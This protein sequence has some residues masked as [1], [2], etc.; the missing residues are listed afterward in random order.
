VGFMVLFTLLLFFCVVLHE[1]GHSLVAQAFGVKVHDITLWPIGGVARLSNMPRRPAHEFLI[2]AA[3]PAVNILL[4]VM[5][6]VL[7]FGLIGPAQLLRTFTTGRG[8]ARLLGGQTAESLVLLLALQNVLLALFNLVPAFPLDGGRLLRS[9]LAGFLPFRTATRTASYIGQGVA[10]VL[11]GASFIPPGNFFLTLVAAFVFLGAW[12]ERSQVIA[13][14]SLAGLIV[15]DAMQPLGTRLSCNDPVLDTVRRIAAIPQSAF[16]VVE[17]NR[18]AGIMTRGGLLAVAKKAKATETVGQHL[19]RGIAQ[20]P[21]D[22]S[23]VSAQ[24]RLQTEHAAVVVENGVILGL[25]TRSDIARLTE[26]LEVIQ[27]AR[28][29]ATRQ[30]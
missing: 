25:I 16:A 8:L 1:L 5:L 17:G 29:P 27:D 11:F 14:E 19:P 15:R 12:Q 18:L 6:G 22:E 28:P 24:E 3:G 13:L 9:L 4:A 20:V 30:E 26:A 21:P 10:L 7:A 23:L 2:S